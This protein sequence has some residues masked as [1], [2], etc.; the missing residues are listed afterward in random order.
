MEQNKDKLGEM[1][2]HQYQLQERLDVYKRIAGNDSMKQKYINQMLLACH[3]EVT[4]IMRETAYKNPEF[5]EFGWKKGQQANNDNFKKEI[6]DLMHFVINLALVSGMDSTEF[7]E[8]YLN[9]N[10]EN[11][12][13]QDT[14]Y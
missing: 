14:N 6:I 3:E 12:V 10:K 7:Y 13:R 4:E 5:V 9:K 1:F 2:A 11:F 8:R